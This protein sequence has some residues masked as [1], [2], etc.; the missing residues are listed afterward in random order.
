M[1][2]R[3][4]DVDPERVEGSAPR[5]EVRFGEAGG[6]V[7]LG[8]NVVTLNPGERSSDRHW[9]ARSDEFLY[10]LAGTATVIENDG[11][12][13]LRPGDCACWP[14]GVDNAHTVENRTDAPIRFLVAGTNPETDTVRYPDSGRTLY[15][16]PPSW[17]V[18]A[19]DGTVLRE[20]PTD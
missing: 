1:I 7:S 16:E 10:V 11:A 17:R 18:V 5:E 6:L 2:L 14:A 13:D 12:H 8:A 15:H 3:S 4:T 9:H 20:G 19:D